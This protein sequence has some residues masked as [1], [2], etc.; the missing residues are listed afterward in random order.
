M[1][2]VHIAAEK[3]GGFVSHFDKFGR[4][5]VCLRVI[6][7]YRNEISAA[8]YV[9]LNVAFFVLFEE[10]LEIFAFDIAS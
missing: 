10:I 1:V 9:F 3:S 8:V 4:A 6:L 7:I 2:E 5:R